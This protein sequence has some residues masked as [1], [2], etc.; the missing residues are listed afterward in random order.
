MAKAKTKNKHE[1]NPKSASDSQSNGATQRLTIKL[2]ITAKSTLEGVNIPNAE[3]LATMSP[4]SELDTEEV[5][6]FRHWT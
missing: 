5:Y 4:L 3:D 2:P 6:I 1:K